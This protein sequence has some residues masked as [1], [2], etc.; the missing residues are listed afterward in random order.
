MKILGWES[1]QTPR[2]TSMSSSSTSRWEDTIGS[3]A[4]A[5]IGAVLSDAQYFESGMVRPED[6]R[7]QLDSKATKDKLEAMKR[8]VALISLGK[9]ASTFFPD[10]V[11]NVVASSLDVKKLVYLY[12]VHY[13][14]QQPDTALLAI[15]TFQK[16]LSDPSQLIRALALRVLSSIRVKIIMQIVLMAIS[17]GARD[18]SPYVRKTAAYAIPKVYQLDPTCRDALVEPLATLL[19]DRSTSVLGS[20][21]A[22]HQEIFVDDY[23]LLHP[24]YRKLCNSL[25]DMDEW[26]QQIVLQALLFYARANFA[27]PKQGEKLDS[28][29]ELLLKSTTPLFRC[30]SSAVVLLAVAVFYHLAP[31]D[32]FDKF[33]MKPLVRLLYATEP[34][35]RWNAFKVCRF[36][37]RRYPQAFAPYMKEFFVYG[38]DDDLVRNIKIDILTSLAGCG[39]FASS[40][41]R[42]LQDGLLLLHEF[43][44][45]LDANP[46][47][48]AASAARAIGQLALR[49]PKDTVFT[50]CMNILIRNVSSS[51]NEAM[52]AESMFVLRQLLQRSPDK[53]DKVLYRLASLFCANRVN[54]AAARAE[55]CWIIGEFP[56]LS[57]RIGP[58]ALRVLLLKFS[59]ESVVVKL[60]AINLGAK[61]WCRLH[62]NGDRSEAQSSMG[63]LSMLGSDLVPVSE[64]P[65]QQPAQPWSCSTRLIHTMISH[66]FKL[67]KYDVSFDVRDH[68]RLF[69]RL[70]I[71]PIDGVDNLKNV[72]LK[73]LL[74]SK[75]ATTTFGSESE[76]GLAGNLNNL[77][78][79]SGLSSDSTMIG[80][81]SFVLDSLVPGFRSLPPW[82]S[83]W[84]DPSVREVL[85][86]S[87][88]IF[89]GSS[90][91]GVHDSIY[92]GESI[93]A[94]SISGANYG[95]TVQFEVSKKPRK[96]PSKFYEDDDG[97]DEEDDEEETEE[98]ET[99]EENNVRSLNAQTA[100]PQ[101]LKSTQPARPTP[102]ESSDIASDLFG[103]NLFGI[104]WK[105]DQ[106]SSS[107][108]NKPSQLTQLTDLFADLVS[109]APAKVLPASLGGKPVSSSSEPNKP[110][111]STMTWL[112]E[113]SQGYPDDSS[114]LKWH[115]ACEAWHC[116]GLEVDFAFPRSGS[117][118]GHAWTV[119]HFHVTNRGKADV[120][121]VSIRPA[122]K[123]A[124]PEIRLDPSVS[125]ISGSLADKL[126]PGGSKELIMHVNIVNHNA[127]IALE[128]SSSLGTYP[129]QITPD[130]MDIIKPDPSLTWSQ[131]DKEEQAL[132]GMFSQNKALDLP[133]STNPTMLPSP[134]LYWQQEVKNR[135]VSACPNMALIGSSPFAPVIV[136]DA[137]IRFCAKLPGSSN[138]V[139]LSVRLLAQEQENAAGTESTKLSVAISAKCEQVLVAASILTKIVTLFN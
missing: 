105:S 3:Y 13:A 73:S 8:I 30:K 42:F 25:I 41:R 134:L 81:A 53:Y 107:T 37:A 48:F 126:S 99:E 103:G 58:E 31:Y 16:D 24:V 98:E 68:A 88:T 69:S 21:V 121:Q 27:E 12:L 19:K 32:L 78:N 10:V 29:L 117:R 102:T 136:N 54:S 35:I 125:T 120:S 52:V 100:N 70:F 104:L 64:A 108:E 139:L 80:S 26:G 101:A 130:I 135:V 4:F 15:N 128:L 93:S 61:L 50:Q 113:L 40:E 89:K 1:T 116:Q 56:F 91:S 63:L 94:S 74:Q 85:E 92:G 28:D 79:L 110:A 17:K 67:A 51:E 11:K 118:Y 55:I 122:T 133:S 111:G 137:P 47:S 34:S 106:G 39:S 6:I 95:N 72:I 22:A 123:D 7:R 36:V 82:A 65:A 62:E 87:A 60:Q 75:S 76:Q 23:S 77:N 112:S 38:T 45:Y 20:A 83:A 46:P 57:Y 2:S 129:F 114:R 97:D 90:I 66:L 33:A 59:E 86:E 9:D 71:E 127:V 115:R 131:Y 132:A 138:R 43:R 84:S 109:D 124:Q 44:S 49:H 119:I 96:D 18:S 5:Q 14:E